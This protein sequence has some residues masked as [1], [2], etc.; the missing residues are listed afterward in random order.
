M[1]ETRRAIIWGLLVI[2]GAPS[3]RSQGAREPVAEGPSHT[4]QMKCVVKVTADT[5]VMPLS[6]GLLESLLYS[7]GV[8]GAAARRVLGSRHGGSSEFEIRPVPGVY[9]PDEPADS[10]TRGDGEAPRAYTPA[11]I[12]DG[13][14]TSTRTV[15]FALWVHLDD[16]IKPAAREFG[17]ALLE[18]LRAELD[19]AFAAQVGELERQLHEAQ[20]EQEAARREFDN[21]TRQAPQV[22]V[23]EIPF[24][25]ADQML[26]EQLERTVNLSALTPQMPVSKAVELLR[27]SV[28]PPLNIVMLWRDLLENGDIEPTD[29]INMDGLPGVR[30]GTALQNL[31]SAISNPLIAEID[32]VVNNG[33]ITVGTIDGLPPKTMETRLHDVPPLIRATDQTLELMAT[34]RETIAPESWFDLSESGEGTIA[35]SGDGRLIVCQSRDVHRR[36]RELLAKVGGRFSVTVPLEAPQETLM[37]RM[38]SLLPY[39]DKLEEELN[40][41]QERQGAIAREKDERGRQAM[42]DAVAAMMGT[43]YTAANN[44]KRIRADVIEGDPD[45]PKAGRLEQ[46][47]EQIEGCVKHCQNMPVPRSGYDMSFAWFDRDEELT[48][49]NRI[50]DKQRDLREVSRRIAEIQRVLAGPRTFEPEVSRIQWAARHLEQA[51]ARLHDL[52]NRIANLQPCTVTV[53]GT[54]E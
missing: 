54:E 45:D 53:I 17:T 28:Q 14:G 7:D 33:V 38:Q 13:H 15:L 4:R 2:L 31:L 47:I 8:A 20:T 43:L 41:L 26:Y 6:P 39:R 23:D 29:P 52:K 9:G 1:R 22:R 42:R 10:E 48:L 18:A 5:S 44:L 37:E 34:I 30:L 40:R 49:S 11:L 32:C 24:D 46:A 21:A 19:E 25:P 35:P 12:N 36:I 3:T 27:Q 51:N 16:P 50:T